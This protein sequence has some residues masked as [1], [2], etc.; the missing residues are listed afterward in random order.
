MSYQKMF[1][2]P[3]PSSS[4]TSLSTPYFTIGEL[5]S[6]LTIPRTPPRK[7]DASLL[8][9][10]PSSPGITID[11]PEQ[12]LPPLLTMEGL[13]SL[14]PKEPTESGH[15]PRPP[16]AFMLFRSF[17]L[18]HRMHER[19]ENSN[20]QQLASRVAGDLWRSI[21]PE[22]RE[23]WH[24][25]ALLMRD[26]HK[27]QYP[28]YKFSPSPRAV[29]KEKREVKG[30]ATQSRLYREKYMGIPGQA[31][32]PVRKRKQLNKRGVKVEDEDEEEEYTPS[33]RRRAKAARL[34][35]SPMPSSST[36]TGPSA[37]QH[38]AISSL[39]AALSNPDIL[40]NLLAALPQLM[41]HLA[42]QAASPSGSPYGVPTPM[43]Q[44]SAASSSSLRPLL[45]QLFAGQNNGVGFGLGSQVR[46]RLLCSTLTK[47]TSAL[48]SSLW[49]LAPVP[50]CPRFLK[51]LSTTSSG[52]LASLP[53]S[54][55]FVRP[56]PSQ[57]RPLPT[58]SQPRL[59]RTNSLRPT[60]TSSWHF[61]RRSPQRL[62][63]GRHLP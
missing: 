25:R 20:H 24:E 18:K 61:F 28:D 2:Y 53:L 35:P 21:R 15:I 62:F 48:C 30:D 52:S 49:H 59:Q 26:F 54:T 50:P 60:S 17:V 10:P 37:P 27:A 36:A 38:N 19:L 55:C 44:S 5:S 23:A 31:P 6:P 63:P 8:P 51:V 4:D 22:V 16:N 11:N 34:P 33:R 45:P 3:S 41:S 42:L 29:K 7:T 57:D 58:C 39:Q 47:L 9:T 12:F 32:L 14:A 46:L 43:S 40:A 56:L 1:S 13:Q